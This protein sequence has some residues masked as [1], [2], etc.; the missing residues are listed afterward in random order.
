[1]SD[2]K[3]RDVVSGEE[4]FEYTYSAKQQAEIEEIRRKYLPKE[5]DKLALLKKLDSDVTKSGTIW[6][7]VLGVVGVLIFGAGMSFVMV[8]TDTLL[9]PGI[10]LGIIG[11]AVLSLAYPVYKKITEKQKE[12]IAPQILALAEELSK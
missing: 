6:S 7:L 1:M 8:W 4:T 2:I 9:V 11:M 5:E 12:K 10:L 3:E